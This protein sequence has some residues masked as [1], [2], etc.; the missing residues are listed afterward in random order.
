MLYVAA[1]LCPMSRTDSIQQKAPE[2]EITSARTISLPILVG[3]DTIDL[4]STSSPDLS[5]S[6]LESSG[7]SKRLREIGN[8]VIRPAVK[9]ARRGEDEDEQD[10]DPAAD[11]RSALDSLCSRAKAEVFTGRTDRPDLDVSLG[12]WSDE[13][14]NSAMR[15]YVSQLWHSMV[16][17]LTVTD[18]L[19]RTNLPNVLADS[20]VDQVS[21]PHRIAGA[22]LTVS[23]S[24]V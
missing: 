19:A 5:L 21:V 10:S 3:D 2:R 14:E 16:I 11:L 24:G 1:G 7:V 8:V 23:F 13:K 4:V 20:E 17:S 12:R 15:E 6:S 22:E 9:R 18:P